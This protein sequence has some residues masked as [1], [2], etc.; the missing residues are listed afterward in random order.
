MSALLQ[1][2]NIAFDLLSWPESVSF[3]DFYVAFSTLI[4]LTLQNKASTLK[5]IDLNYIF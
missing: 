2:C 1:G 5:Y 4:I 3:R